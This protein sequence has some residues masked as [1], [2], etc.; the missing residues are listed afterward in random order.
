LVHTCRPHMTTESA[1]RN[2]S[3]VDE[4]VYFDLPHTRARTYT[5]I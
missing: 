5:Q 3:W 4:A 1:T 2:P